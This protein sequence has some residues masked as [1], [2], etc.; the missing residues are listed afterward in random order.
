M[1]GFGGWRMP[2]QYASILEEA[3]LVRT[4]CGLFDL[5]H[6]GR[7]HVTGPD[8]V[9]LVDRVTTNHCAK[10]PATAIRYALLLNEAGYPLD[11]LLVYREEGDG[12][13]LVVN[14]SNTARDLAWILEHKGDLDARVEDQTDASAMLA[15]QGPDSLD[16]LSQVTE[17]SD[18]ASLK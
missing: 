16:I 13:Y 8:A 14:A 17:D 11:D 18:L 7:F 12:V 5:G 10:I 15:L 2:V 3:K 6:M 4:H 1:V 9:R